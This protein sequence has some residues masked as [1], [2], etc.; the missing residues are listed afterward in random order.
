MRQ[1]TITGHDNECGD[2]MYVYDVNDFHAKFQNYQL[3][4]TNNQVH[5]VQTICLQD[6]L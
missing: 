5:I 6:K 4:H 1:A 2:D 3:K